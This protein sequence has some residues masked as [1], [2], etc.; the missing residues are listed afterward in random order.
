MLR[1][2]AGFF[3]YFYILFAGGWMWGQQL[4]FNDPLYMK[5]VAGFFAS[6]VICQVADVMICRTR[7]QSIFKKGFF[8]NRVVLLGIAAELAL[9]WIIVYFPA[10]QAFFGTQPLTL[11]ELSL[12]VPF[13]LLILLGDEIR[14]LFV[15]KDNEF[16]KKYPTW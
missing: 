7:R 16:V 12:A 4:A 1:A 2:A 5:A 8:T 15:R 11:F 3:T 6:I 14:K 13:A 10:T 9:L